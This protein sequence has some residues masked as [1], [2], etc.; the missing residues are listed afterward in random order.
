MRLPISAGFIAGCLVALAACHPHRPTEVGTSSLRNVI[1][2]DQIDSSRAANIY[3]VI[4]KLHGEFLRDR[5][6]TSLRMNQHERA[7]V[8]LNDQ[9]YGILETM[10]NIPIG[11]I[12]EIRYFSGPDAVNRFGAQYGGGVV[13]LV[14]R[15]Q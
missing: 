13:M 9:E 5:G 3:D 2:Q 15:N 1:T 10:R 7:V 6:R 4:T 11:R 12:S 8:F 14:S